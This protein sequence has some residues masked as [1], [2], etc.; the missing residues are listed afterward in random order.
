MKQVMKKQKKIFIQL[1]IFMAIVLSSC[2]VFAVD[3]SSNFKETKFSD[4]FLDYLELSDE[5]KEKT[6]MPRPYE[7]FSTKTTTTNPL[8]KARMLRSSLV[9]SY[10]LKDVIPE[11]MV[12]KDQKQ[13]GS[14]W[15]FSALAG[16]ESNLA[17]KNYKSGITTPI[18][19]DFSERHMEYAT[20]QSFLNGA[21]NE[22]GFARQVGTGGSYSFAIPYLTNGTGAIAEAEMPFENNEDSIYITEIQNKKVITQVND[23]KVFASYTSADD[24]TEIIKEMKEHI[25]NYGAIDASIYGAQLDPN[26][27]VYNNETGAIYCNDSDLYPVNHGVAII[28]WNDNYPKTNFVEGNQPKNNGAWIIKNSW[29]TGG[30][31]TLPEMKQYIFD[32]F[33]TDCEK[34]G[35]TSPDKISDEDAIYNFKNWG[36]TIDENNVATLKI[37][38]NGF[39]YVSYEDANIYL[40]LNG[41]MDA[42]DEVDYENIYQ[43]DK[44]GANYYLSM[45]APK[46][47]LAQVFQKKTDGKEYLTQVSVNT[48]ETYTCKVYVNPNGTGKAKEDFQQVQ[49]KTGE[50]ETFDAG[51][52]TIEFLEPIKITGNNFVVLLE[53]EG[54]QANTVTAMLEGNIKELGLSTPW[55]N[56]TVESDKCF[57]TIDETLKE[58]SWLDTSMIYSQSYGTMPSGD[59]TIKAFTTS[60]VLENISVTTVPT[61]TKYV[62]GQDFDKTGMIITANYANGNAIAVTDYTIQDG[63]N[64]AL[65]QESVTIA[66]QNKTV[67]QPISVVENK[68][69]NIT[70]KTAP[71]T[72]EYWAGD[73]F[74]ATGMVVEAIYTDGT[75]KTVPSTE[76]TIKDGQ[77][78]KNNQTSI[79]IEYKGKTVTQAIIVKINVVT[80]IEV[81]AEAT[82]VEYVAGQ[83][84]DTTGLKIKAIYA[85][86]NKKEVTDYT[87]KDGKDL[88]LGQ[89]TVTIEYEGQTT[90]QSI[91][92]IEKAVTGITIKNM[93]T[94]TKY[95][96]EKEELDL[97]GGVIEIAY[98]DGAKEELSMTST[99]ITANGFDNKEVGKQ[100]ITLEYEG[101]TVQFEIEIM[102][103]AKPEN[104]NFDNTQGKVAR[105]R[106]YSFTDKNKKEYTVLNVELDNI[107]KATQNEKMEYYYYLSAN[108]KDENI[109][110]WVEMPE[111]EETE[112][113]ISFEINTLNLSNYEEL[114]EAQ[115]IYLYV[116]EVATRNDMKTE[117]I[118]SS[119]VL[120]TG[121]V[122]VEEYVDGEEIT[123]VDSTPAEKED[124][125]EDNTKAPGSIP[126][127][128]K[129]V[130]MICLAIAIIVI[131]KFAYSKYKDIQIK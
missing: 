105:I 127:T 47:Y 125:K 119:L 10:S 120:N 104:S 84:F 100:T 61:K 29:G 57:I 38:D 44:F 90:T 116:K 122:D 73:D 128:G 4:E 39:M 99:E 54:T 15:T 35:W 27:A 25:K 106:S 2:N 107:E 32:N 88:K 98:N 56:V 50:T 64:L 23:V 79:T 67:I 60:K 92:V 66:Y 95:I 31:Y 28:G 102:E 77:A 1:L 5:E 93:P 129:D 108:P 86:G 69:E 123:R 78:L 43:Y 13:T 18:V 59:T 46:V 24:K 111:P 103:L 114:A 52:H 30:K 72:T 130:L 48:A 40:Q 110:D 7:V 16:L 118:T 101:K 96:Q 51:Y 11:N 109:T 83:N 71:T 91:T 62:V 70:I 55:D 34:L 117:K 63:K 87:V 112:T 58:D 89:T 41:I 65:N 21:V 82:K 74:D 115:S 97:T 81:V 33:P 49:L 26:S 124:S 85:N 22:N 6:M 17:L 76:Y 131:G 19:Y 45:A 121:K 80:K 75:T 68:V 113:G 53:I 3:F 14:C 37:G 20:S 8:R 126:K 9:S 12:I 42:Q 94:K 36:F